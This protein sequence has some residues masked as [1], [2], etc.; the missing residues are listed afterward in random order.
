MNNILKIHNVCVILTACII[1]SAC[2]SK[3]SKAD[4][5]GKV[6]TVLPDKIAEVCAMRLEVKDFNHEV[7]SN[8]TVAARNRANLNF[9]VQGE[10]A[11]INVKN[12]DRVRKGQKLAQLDRFELQN[13]LEQAETSLESAKLNYLNE[14]IGMGYTI[15]DTAKVPYEERRL[16]SIKSGLKQSQSQYEIAKYNFDNSTL[17]AP[18]DGVVANLFSKPYNKPEDE[19]FCTIIDNVHLEVDFRILE[20]ELGAVHAGDKVEVSPFSLGDYTCTGVI[21]EINPVVDKNGMVRVKAAINSAD[22]KLYEGMN[23]KLLLKQLVGKQLVIPKSALL[24][25][26]NRK[27]VFRLENEHAFWVYVTT[28]L[29]NA[30]EYVVTEGLQAGDSVIYEGNMNLAHETPVRVKN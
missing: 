4:E 10:V 25:R 27:V 8:G 19:Q 3:P 7:A 12:G 21:S 15:A 17:Y 13:A 16:A 28:T 9:K 29:E 5:D 30:S 11:E 22:G 20:N 18:F 24:L 2:T 26:D 23:V 14:L 6:Q 1:T